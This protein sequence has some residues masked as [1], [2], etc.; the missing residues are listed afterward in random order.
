MNM[1]TE[2]PEKTHECKRCGQLFDQLSP[3]KEHERT[4]PEE[5]PYMQAL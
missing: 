1:A 2:V 5:K 4:H 3:Y